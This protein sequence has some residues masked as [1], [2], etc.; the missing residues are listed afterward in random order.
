MIQLLLLCRVIG[1]HRRF[2]GFVERILVGYIFQI[3][4]H[5][6]RLVRFVWLLLS[7]NR[8]LLLLAIAT[9]EVEYVCLD[10]TEGVVV[11]DV[12]SVCV[13]TLPRLG[14]LVDD[15]DTLRGHAALF[16][17]R[18]LLTCWRRCRFYQLLFEGLGLVE[19]WIRGFVTFFLRDSHRVEVRHEVV[20]RLGA[21]ERIWGL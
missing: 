17:L 9:F 4:F 20:D 13:L 10:C 11:A 21:V 19:V 8:F 1:S 6:H 3:Y 5:S 15:V 16:R 14:C 7:A 2:L 12:E 18:G